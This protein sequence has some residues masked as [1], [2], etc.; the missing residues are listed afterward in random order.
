MTA[1]RC[2]TPVI[3]MAYPNANVHSFVN[4]L[5]GKSK[6]ASLRTSAIAFSPVR[7]KYEKIEEQ[8]PRGHAIGTIL[9]T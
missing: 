2:E 1:W 8:W 3:P 7:M 6:K 9:D 5:F 4:A